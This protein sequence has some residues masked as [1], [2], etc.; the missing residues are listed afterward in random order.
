MKNIATAK[1]QG[2]Q[3]ALFEA[4]LSRIWQHVQD[5][6]NKSFAIITS[7]RQGYSRKRNLADFGA[8]K[9]S[10]RSLG[11]G[12][13]QVQGHWKECQDPDVAYADCPKEELVDAVEPSLFVTGI[14]QK[15]VSVLGKLHKQDAVVYA[16]PETKGRVVLLFADG[17][18]QDIGDFKPQTM[19]QAFS[20]L[21]KSKEGAS[22]S[23]KFEGLEYKAMG[24]L[25]N[26]IEQEVKKA[27]DNDDDVS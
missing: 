10:V 18:T 7:W 11:L 27:L 14:S 2:N 15:D 19:G 9:K 23:F 26:L 16:G 6:E 21:R 8:L 13:V 1:H 5:S 17:A 25:E 3:A 20:E 22:R 24:Y 4:S 12:F